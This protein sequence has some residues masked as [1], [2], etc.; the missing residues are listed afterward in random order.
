MASSKP[1]NTSY[2]GVQKAAIM[3]MTVD[4]DVASKIFSMM[5]EDEI[6]EISHAMSGLG[7][8]EPGEVESLVKE[9]SDEVSSGKNIVG[10]INN[11]HKIL[12]KALGADKVATILGDISSPM[13]KDTW[14]K[15]NN[16]SEDLLSSYLKNEHPQTVALILSKIRTSH[17]SKV[18]SILPEDFAFEVIRRMINL[19][20]VKREVLIDIEKILQMEFMANLSAKKETDGFEMMAEIF[21]NFDRSTEGKF[22]ELLDKKDPAISERIRELMF[23]FEDL[24]K[25]DGP[26]IQTVLRNADKEKLPIALKGA[27]QEIKDLFFKNMSERGAKILV[28]EI[29]SLGPVRISDVDEAQ[30]SIVNTAKRLADSGEI[31]IPEGDEDE[32]QMIY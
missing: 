14:D 25:L 20:P 31:T 5:T 17:A 13:G 32:E 15:L 9:F 12:S 2:N 28:E 4:E 21:N 6:R 26:S 27:T 7:K 18:L 30:M 1:S 3:L 29:E 24:L 11:A 23:T 8:V 22:F 19:E 10:D 16:V